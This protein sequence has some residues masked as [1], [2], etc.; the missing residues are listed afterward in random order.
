MQSGS[1]E[2]AGQENAGPK[3]MGGKCETGK[4]RIKTAGVENGEIVLYVKTS[5]V[6]NIILIIV[7]ISTLTH[8]R[9]LSHR[10]NKYFFKNCRLELKLEGALSLFITTSKAHN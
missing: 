4:Y 10:C 8:T 3:C 7:Q 5:Y 9:P 1:I 6:S 2:N